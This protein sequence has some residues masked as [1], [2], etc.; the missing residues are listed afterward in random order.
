MTVAEIMRC[1]KPLI[2]KNEDEAFSYSMLGTVFLGRYGTRYFGISAQHNLRNRTKESIRLEVNPGDTEFLPLN[3]IHLP[4][5]PKHDSDFCDLAFFEVDPS[6]LSQSVLASNHFLDLEYF[7]RLPCVFHA[8]SVLIIRGYPSDLNT[9]N[10]SEK[11]IH[12]QA[13]TT[14]ATYTG[15]AESVHC[16]SL[17]FNDLSD[18]EDVDG[19]SGSPVMKFEKTHYG[20]T[21]MFAGVLIRATKSSSQGRFIK[22]E[23]VF[24]ALQIIFQ[25]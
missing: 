16:G 10:Y 20:H 22:A 6:L 14:E 7:S 24:R 1:A 18:V 12:T 11:I 8:D 4:N 2:F 25:R 23:V 13:Y 21:F 5:I 15:V 9:I 3:S 19:M 17:V